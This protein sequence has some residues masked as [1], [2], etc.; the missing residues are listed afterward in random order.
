MQEVF[1]EESATLIDE[2]KATKKYNFYNL[3]SKILYVIFTFYA[4]IVFLFFGP[5]PGFVVFSIIL[6]FLPMIIILVMAIMCGRYKNTLYNVYDY[7][8]VSGSI[9]VSKVIKDIN[10]KSVIK[11]DTYNIERIGY[12]NSA[13]YKKYESITGINKLVLT[14]NLIPAENKNF[15]YFVVNVNAQKNL[16]VFECTQQFIV[17]VIKFSK[18]TILEEEFFK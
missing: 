11:F 10:R 5:E 9:R 14:Q 18:K 16:L 8:F 13:T 1:Y 15:Y 4:I 12:F 2:E 17:N 6:T 7:T 3:I